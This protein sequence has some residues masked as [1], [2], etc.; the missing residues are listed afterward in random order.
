MITEVLLFDTRDICIHLPGLCMG[1][2]PSEQEQE[3]EGEDRQGRL[4]RLRR[5]IDQTYYHTIST[6][7]RSWF[8]PLPYV[9]M[10]SQCDKSAP[11][12]LRLTQPREISELANSMALHSE[13]T[14]MRCAHGLGAITTAGGS[15]RRRDGPVM[16]CRGVPP[17]TREGDRVLL[18]CGYVAVWTVGFHLVPAC[19][20]KTFS[21]RRV[22]SSALQQ[23]SQRWSAKSRPCS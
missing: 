17:E 2:I 13:S 14:K 23:L 7:F 15:D 1:C 22:L 8:Y 11:H 12:V 10:Q 5:A 6:Y 18:A 3:E 9:Y 4:Q 19:G 16:P 20:Y 21:S